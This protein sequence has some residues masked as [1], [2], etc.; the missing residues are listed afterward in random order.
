M[1][2]RILT[3]NWNGID[4]LK[5]LHPGLV[6][7][8]NKTNQEW[9]WYIRDNGST[10]NSADW[11]STLGN[12]EVLAVD[13]NRDNFSQ[14]VNSLFKLANPEPNDIIILL[15]NDIV[16]RDD[17]SIIRM[18]DLLNK[19]GAAICGA[20]LMYPGSNTIS[21]SGIVFDKSKNDMPWNYHMGMKLQPDDKLN[22]YFQAVTAACCLFKAE[23]FNSIGGFEESLNWAFDDVWFCLEASIGLGRKIVCCGETEI[24]HETSAS[25]NKNPIHKLFLSKNVKLFR[26]KWFGKYEIDADKYSQPHYNVVK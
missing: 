19:T 6:K 7:N 11:L 13:H 22:R 23:L 8:L 10:D 15:N 1:T 24:D 16:F 5:A 26:D 9:K 17:Q 25:L 12:V 4:K 18:I 20:R 2:L 14:G 21:H 3:L